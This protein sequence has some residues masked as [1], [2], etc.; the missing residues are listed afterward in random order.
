MSLDFI[1]NHFAEMD[2]LNVNRISF[3]ALTRAGDKQ[4]K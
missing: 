1:H 4:G 3:L 2:K